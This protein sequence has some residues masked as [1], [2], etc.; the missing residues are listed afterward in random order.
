MRINQITNETDLSEQD[1]IVVPGVGKKLKP[2]F[3]SKQDDRRDHEV[4]MA[5]S[6]LFSTAKNA[7]ALYDLIKDISEDEGLPGWVQEKIIKANDYLN[8]VLEY[9][10]HKSYDHNGMMSEKAVSKAQQKFM[11]M[12][13]A[14]QKGEKPASKAVADVA[15]SMK[16]KDAK[17]FASTKHKGLP[18]KVEEDKPCWDG[19]EQYGM[20]TKNGK[21]VPNCVPKPKK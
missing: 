13:H 8:T 1:L 9:I 5:K 20:K 12:V 10:Q 19:Y 21:K 16:K 2:G 17:D 6:D 4:E 11:G 7:K 15:K 18:D 3:I 14:A